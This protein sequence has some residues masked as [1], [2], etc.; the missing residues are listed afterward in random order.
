MQPNKCVPM[1]AKH[2]AIIRRWPSL[3]SLAL[4]ARSLATL[5][6]V[7][8]FVACDEPEA[9][10]A[11]APAVT[12][13]AFASGPQNP[14]LVAEGKTIFRFD[15]FGDETF[16]TDTL[17]MHEV[18]RTSVSPNMALEVGLKVDADALPP[19]V[20]AGILKSADALK[21]S[22]AGKRVQFR[23]H[24]KASVTDGPFAETKELVA[25]YWIWEV[26]SM[27]EAM[28]WALRIPDPTPGEESDIEIRPFYGPE[29]FAEA[30]SPDQME[31]VDEMHRHEA[32]QQR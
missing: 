2:D 25:G 20:K 29:D 1:L 16:W 27:D 22:S 26:K 21:P 32:A 6:A 24:R 15:T 14:A 28:D 5:A 3:R 4:A 31:R 23:P 10:D 7:M 12:E 19:E 17:R 8:V 11:V 13:P 9:R 18:I 30:L